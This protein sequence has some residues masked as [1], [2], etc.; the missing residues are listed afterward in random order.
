M[1]P[2]NTTKSSEPNLKNTGPTPHGITGTV[3]D[4]SAFT[5]TNKGGQIIEFLRSNLYSPADTAVATVKII[6]D[7]DFLMENM[8]YSLTS[9]NL[10]NKFLNKNGSINPY[11][12]QI[13]TE[14]IFK[15]AEDYNLD[16]GLLDVDK[17]QT[18]GF[19]SREEQA[20]IKNKGIIFRINSVT[21]NFS[22]GKFEQDLE[23]FMVFP[24]ELDMG[25]QNNTS[26]STTTTAT[27]GTWSSTNDQ[28][29]YP[30]EPVSVIDNSGSV[31]SA[32]L[33]PVA[34]DTRTGQIKETG[35]T[36]RINN[37]NAFVELPVNV[38][39]TSPDDDA[40][41]NLPLP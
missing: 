8:G 1:T 15:V 37:S 35:N 11:G 21:S 9:G 3:N 23:M 29:R 28:Y 32:K 2:H 25:S 36:Q 30:E 38:S 31:P 19:Y 34:S 10:S 41:G 7:P 20:S 13:F 17:E 33:S 12:G 26:D 18:I 14:I 6:G 24:S 5:N 39:P 16:T 27:S 4:N 40:Y 22:K